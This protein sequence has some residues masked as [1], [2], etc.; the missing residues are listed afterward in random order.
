VNKTRVLILGAS[1]MLGSMVTDFMSLDDSL[2]V[3][4]TVRSPE[5]I[6]K[7]RQRIKNVEWQIFEVK[8]QAQT[9][10]QLKELGELEW[11]VN[12]IGIIKPYARDDHPQDVERAIIGNAAFPYWLARTFERSRILQIATDCVYSGKKGQ[13]TES[14]KHDALDVYGKTKSL[15]EVLLPNV[16]HFRCSIIGPEPKNYVSLL[17]WF[18]RQPS[19]AKVSGFKNHF[20]NGVTTLHFAK[21]CHGIIKEKTSLPHLQHIIPS[22]DITKHDLLCCLARC[23][24]RSDIDITPVDAPQIIDRRLVTENE[25]LNAQLWK[26]AGYKMCPPTIEEMVEEMAAF[27]CGL[28]GLTE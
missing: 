21:I 14:D 10:Q 11:I 24:N 22:G 23:Y 19:R 5:L 3:V 7:A 13:Y 8:G 26:S 20:W 2:A 27:E 17:E 25:Q 15:G 4:A 6:R 9:V 18:R 12:A 28:E 16:N 1:G